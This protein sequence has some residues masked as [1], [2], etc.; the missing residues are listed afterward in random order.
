MTA[1]TG[2]LDRPVLQL[3][4]QI[5]LDAQTSRKY[6]NGFRDCRSMKIGSTARQGDV[7][8]TR[9][10]HA[11]HISADSVFTFY[12]AKIE[13]VCCETWLGSRHVINCQK[14]ASDLRSETGKFV[15]KYGLRNIVRLFLSEVEWHL[16]HPEH[17]TMHFGP[18]VFAISRQLDY[19]TSAAVID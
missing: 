16:V 8:V 5:K 17:G 7:Y 6:A 11:T 9:V 19:A 13:K 2:L 14:G 10:D 4:N 18:G 3:I 12:D 1:K 15:E